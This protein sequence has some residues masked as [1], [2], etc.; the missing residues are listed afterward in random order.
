MIVLQPTLMTPC[1]VCNC[2]FEKHKHTYYKL[3]KAI[4][5]NCKTIPEE[6]LIMKIEERILLEL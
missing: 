2:L 6:T 1:Y 5:D 3:E 4:C